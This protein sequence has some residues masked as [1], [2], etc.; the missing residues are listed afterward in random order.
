MWLRT[1]DMCGW[2][3]PATF[4]LKIL[5]QSIWQMGLEWDE[6]LLQNL[7]NKWKLWSEE[8]QLIVRDYAL[9][10]LTRPHPAV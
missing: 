5:L 1:F 8:L 10:P 4:S 9:L 3:T 2:Y 7:C 6:E